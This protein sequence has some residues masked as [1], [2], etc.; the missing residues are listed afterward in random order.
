MYIYPDIYSMGMNKTKF[1]VVPARPA[2]TRMFG[3]IKEK[4][5]YT[6]GG[7]VKGV[8]ESEKAEL[9]AEGFKVFSYKMRDY[10]A[11]V[12]IWGR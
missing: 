9:E 10:D 2:E 11:P 4:L 12:T 7:V 5:V 1:K 6:D 3:G 8:M